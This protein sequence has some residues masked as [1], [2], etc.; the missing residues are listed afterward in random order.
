MII[1]LTEEQ[2]LH[3]PPVSLQ[4]PCDKCGK[5]RE[6]GWLKRDIGDYSVVDE[7]LVIKETH[8]AVYLC[9]GCS[10]QMTCDYKRFN[11]YMED[12]D[13]QE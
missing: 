7:K 9:S 11:K 10:W 5:D 12:E 1:G 3:L 13:E 8:T 6:Y 2:F 4:L